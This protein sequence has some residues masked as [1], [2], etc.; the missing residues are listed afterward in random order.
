MLTARPLF[1]HSVGLGYLGA[2]GLGHFRDTPFPAPL[3]SLRGEPMRG[4]GAGWG[5]S[6]FVSAAGDAFVAGREESTVE[7][8]PTPILV[9]FIHSG[10]TSSRRVPEDQEPNGCHFGFSDD[11]FKYLHEEVN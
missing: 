7:I 6:A 10:N 8:S 1:A 4:A 9:S 2:L 3:P 11:Y 5:H